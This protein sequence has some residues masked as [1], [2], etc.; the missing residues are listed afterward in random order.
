MSADLKLS[1]FVRS[2]VRPASDYTRLSLVQVL[3]GGG[4]NVLRNIDI[5]KET[6]YDQSKID[7]ITAEFIATAQEDADGHSGLTSYCVQALKGV[8]KGERSPK[9][10]LRSQDSEFSGD[11]YAESEP[12]SKDGHLAQLMR[13]N[14]G[15]M[16]MNV[17]M[18]EVMSNQSSAIIA[19]QAEQIKHYEDRHWET[20]VRAEELADER[21]N[22]EIR[23]L[24]EIGK[25]KRFNEALATF[26]PL[27]PVVVSKLKGV[28]ADAKAA[29]NLE[30]LK[31]VMS[32][33][34]GD[35]MEQIANIL[36]PQS[37]ALLELWLE[38]NKEKQAEEG[39]TPH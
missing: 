39:A 15:L 35:K 36:G 7:E 28:P 12:A 29:L 34:D 4:F 20:M 14:E 25:E 37:L 5:S 17:Q 23:K 8:T 31:A 26:K 22:R 30:A 32:N 21:D 16:R 9:F 1:K 6:V 24:R 33:L 2:A 13:H 3:N 11:E 19:R 38:A 10:R 27:V 18:M